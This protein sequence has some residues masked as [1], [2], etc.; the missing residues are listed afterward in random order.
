ML[1]T[2]RP[3]PFRLGELREVVAMKMRDSPVHRSLRS[4]ERSRLFVVASQNQTA[5]TAMIG[6]VDRAIELAQSTQWCIADNPSQALD[7]S[8][9]RPARAAILLDD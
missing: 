8:L 5:A 3:P 6:D 7:A 4:S 2:A 1:G 9:V